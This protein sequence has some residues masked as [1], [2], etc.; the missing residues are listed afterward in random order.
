MEE[1]RI[2]EVKHMDD[3]NSLLFTIWL[4]LGVLSSI[5]R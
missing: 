2:E 5:V 1:Q 4:Y 3:L